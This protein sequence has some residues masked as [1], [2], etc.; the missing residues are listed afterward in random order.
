L[1]TRRALRYNGNLHARPYGGALA[2]E[3]ALDAIGDP[4][5][6]RADRLVL[7]SPMI[8]VTSLARFAGFLGLPALLPSFAKAARLVGGGLHGEHA[9]HHR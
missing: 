1:P 6:P 2:M 8:G 4:R 7:L 9:R 5:L 3:Y